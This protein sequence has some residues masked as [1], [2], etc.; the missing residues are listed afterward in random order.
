MENKGTYTP[1]R[2][3]SIY[4]WRTMHHDQFKEYQNKW[5]IAGMLKM[6]ISI[7]HMHE[8]NTAMIQKQNGYAIYS[9]I[10]ASDRLN[11]ENN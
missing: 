7:G 10:Y 1:G 8:T 4:K 9:S 2:K 6:L 3:L 5:G 11:T